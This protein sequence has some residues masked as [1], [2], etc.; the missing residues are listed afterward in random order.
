MKHVTSKNCGNIFVIYSNISVIHAH[1][2]RTGTQ[3]HAES[4]SLYAREAFRGLPTELRTSF[5]LYVQQLY[6]QQVPRRSCPYNLERVL[7]VAG[8]PVCTGDTRTLFFYCN[9]QENVAGLSA[10]VATRSFYVGKS[11]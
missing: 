10:T 2:R 7:S 9:R 1:I 11:H 8:P 5:R 6:A 4:V 3:V